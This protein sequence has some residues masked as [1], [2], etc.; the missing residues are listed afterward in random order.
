VK[1]RRSQRLAVEL[2]AGLVELFLTWEKLRLRFVAVPAGVV[3]SVVC[4]LSTAVTRDVWDD[5]VVDD[6]PLKRTSQ[7]LP[8][9]QCEINQMKTLTPL[10]I[11]LLGVPLWE[12]HPSP[13]YP[14]LN[15]G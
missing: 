4:L 1:F 5:R 7:G 8:V 2:P 13:I 6:A 11:L 14:I 10:M 15:S 3:Q 12:E 9:R